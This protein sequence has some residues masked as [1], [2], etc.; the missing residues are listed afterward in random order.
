MDMAR[1]EN[2]YVEGSSLYSRARS[3]LLGEDDSDED[4]EDYSGMGL[5]PQERIRRIARDGAEE[6]EDALGIEGD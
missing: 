2:A 1:Q 5:T 4:V 6:I 3:F